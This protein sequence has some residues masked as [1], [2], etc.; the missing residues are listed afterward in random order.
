MG[1]V[2]RSRV[3]NKAPRALSAGGEGHLAAFFQ[4]QM[5]RVSRLPEMCGAS[6]LVEQ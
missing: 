1:A 2:W 3:C 5:K 4:A 6:Y